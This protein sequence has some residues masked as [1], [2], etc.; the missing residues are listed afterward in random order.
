MIISGKIG[1]KYSG[2]SVPPFSEWKKRV[3]LSPR[4]LNSPL[5]LPHLSLSS[6]HPSQVT[7]SPG[8]LVF[9]AGF[10]TPSTILCT[11]G[12]YPFRLLVFNVYEIKCIYECPCYE[13][14]L[15]FIVVVENLFY[16]DVVSR[17]T[18]EGLHLDADL[19]SV[20]QGTFTCRT[21]G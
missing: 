9:V 8:S 17:K 2:L 6:P 20:S 19:R 5:S 21:K 16:Y 13:R 18:R 12:T 3:K 15:D 10:T 11:T 7:L 4:M 14:L 1:S